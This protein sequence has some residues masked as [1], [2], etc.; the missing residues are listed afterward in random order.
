M[1]GTVGAAR[2][3]ARLAVALVLV[4]GALVLWSAVETGHAW[5]YGMAL[6]G[7][8]GA[9]LFAAG[10]ERP[11]RPSSHTL[12]LVGWFLMLG[13]S[14]VPTSFLFLPSCPRRPLRGAVGVGVRGRTADR[15]GAARALTLRRSDDP[16]RSSSPG[17]R[18]HR[19]RRSRRSSPCSRR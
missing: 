12:R 15:T 19:R 16:G 7:L 9:A 4:L 11:R 2:W 14:L 13:F 17:G 1:A 6:A 8:S 18:P 5:L 10:I 3:T